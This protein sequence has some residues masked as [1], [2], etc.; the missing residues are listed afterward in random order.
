MPAARELSGPAI[1]GVASV[2]EMPS[3]STRLAAPY[4]ARLVSRGLPAMAG[5]WFT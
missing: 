3:A 4:R 5:S 2:L 1:S